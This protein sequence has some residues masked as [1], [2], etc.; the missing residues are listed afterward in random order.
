M[1]ETAL[2]TTTERP[3]RG[4][5]PGTGRGPVERAE[6]RMREDLLAKADRL[7]AA[8]GMSRNAWL[9]RLVERATT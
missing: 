5:P 2:N 1:R 6:L 8:A 3:R 7:A 9:E 4:R